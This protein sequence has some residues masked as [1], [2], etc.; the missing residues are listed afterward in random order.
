ML[1]FLSRVINHT[2]C[3][4]KTQN[5]W[6]INKSSFKGRVGYNG[7]LTVDKYN[8]F[9]DIDSLHHGAKC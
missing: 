8:I 9:Y 1:T 7:A 5:L 2:L 3:L 6:L 4:V